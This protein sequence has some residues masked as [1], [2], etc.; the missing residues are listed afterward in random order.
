[1]KSALELAM[2]RADA[3]VGGENIKLNDEQKAAIDGIRKLYEAKWA[4]K[5]LQIN[6]RTAKLAQENPEGLA[7]ARGQLLRETN[8]LRQQIFAERDAKIEEVRQQK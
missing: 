8:A 2:E 3:A 6:E 5:E 4:E 7:E 1:M